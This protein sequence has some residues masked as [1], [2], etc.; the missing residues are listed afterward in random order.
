[1][2]VEWEI[3]ISS[4][5][6]SGVI[7]NGKWVS[8]QQDADGRI[9]QGQELPVRIEVGRSVIRKQEE[10]ILLVHNLKDPARVA[11]ADTDTTTYKTDYSIKFSLDMMY[12][13]EIQQQEDGHLVRPL[14]FHCY[15]CECMICIYTHTYI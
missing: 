13:C 1:M 7:L 9:P 15:S 3:A 2:T 5:H 10:S 14:Q 6:A 8:V 4:Q 12:I 11:D